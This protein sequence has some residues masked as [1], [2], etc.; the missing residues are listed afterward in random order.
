M[1]EVPLGKIARIECPNETLPYGHSR[2]RAHCTLKPSCPWQGTILR[3]ENCPCSAPISSLKRNGFAPILLFTGLTLHTFICS[4]SDFAIR[5]TKKAYQF[6]RR[7]MSTYKANPCLQH[8]R[9]RPDAFLQ[10]QCQCLLPIAY[11]LGLQPISIAKY[12]TPH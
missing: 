3:S 8:L 1:R 2:N 9:L 10:C 7:F 12:H 11:C 5:A 4:I 6:V